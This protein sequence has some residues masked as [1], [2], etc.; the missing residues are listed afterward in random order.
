MPR[1]AHCTMCSEEVR[2]TPD[3]K[4]PL[5]HPAS[6]LTNHREASTSAGLPRDGGVR[7]G[8]S[9]PQT[10]TS[11]AS[12]GFGES[13]GTPSWL[14]PTIIVGI[15]IAVVVFGALGVRGIL[16][17][18]SA[19][20]LQSYDAQLG[21]WLLEC[22][23]AKEMALAGQAVSGNR[24]L[25]EESWET[26]QDR[27]NALY[28]VMSQSTPPEEREGLHAMAMSEVR[29]WSESTGFLLQGQWDRATDKAEEANA[30]REEV[31]REIERINASR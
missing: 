20:R 7:E 23:D 15:V 27:L 21:M 22:D 30:V 3:G 17:S 9:T 29:L 4:C 11:V 6:A 25:N 14:K 31:M 16:S 13:P 18:S 10:A 26:V 8:V 12:S 2:V 5:G 28:S 19:A 1:V 24:E